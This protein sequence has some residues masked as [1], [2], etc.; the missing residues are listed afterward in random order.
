M[1]SKRELVN[2]LRAGERLGF[3]LL[4]RTYSEELYRYILGIVKDHHDAEVWFNLTYDE[5]GSTGWSRGSMLRPESLSM[6]DASI[7]S[8][9]GLDSW[10]ESFTLLQPEEDEYIT[11][12]TATATIYCRPSLN[13]GIICRLTDT[14]FTVHT[15]PREDGSGIE[16]VFVTCTDGHGVYYEGWAVDSV[17]M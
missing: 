9:E 7:F 14:D 8:D 12:R 5:K 10:R 6:M 13:A 15:A 4:C 11:E 2:S 3:D 17:I 1:G 16:W